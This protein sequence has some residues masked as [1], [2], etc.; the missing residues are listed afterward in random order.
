MP[1]S[2]E[3]SKARKPFKWEKTLTGL[4]EDRIKPFKALMKSHL[5]SQGISRVLD[6]GTQRLLPLPKVWG[7]FG[8]WT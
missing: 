4:Y 5:A 6:V 8:V 7:D 1:E 3:E 2:Q